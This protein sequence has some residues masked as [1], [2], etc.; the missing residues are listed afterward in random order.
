MMARYHAGKWAEIGGKK[1]FFRSKWERNYARWLEW[2]K[3][4][5]LILDWQ[6]EPRTFW[7][8]GIKRGCVSY[9]PDFYIVTTQGDE[10]WIEVKGYYDA[11]S[12]TKI[13]RFRKY[14]PKE[15]LELVD[16][17]FFKKNNA[18]LK[19]LVPGWE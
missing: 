2:Q 8:D 14:F 1:I 4:R 18:K 15:R 17:E 10:K 11:R 12:F 5:G 9:K 16:K 7:F 13:R 3:G 6:Y 19:L